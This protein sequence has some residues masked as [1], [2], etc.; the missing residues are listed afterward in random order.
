V[1]DV[2]SRADLTTLDGRRF[3][4]VLGHFPTG[5]AVVAARRADGYP[6]GMVVGSFTSVSLDP[7][8]VAFLPDRTSTTWPVIKASGSFCVSVLGDRQ[9]AVCRAFAAKGGDKFA[10]IGWTPA[11]SG[12][13]IIDGAVAY[14]D[15][16]IET[17]HE[18]GD[19]FIVIGRVRE[20]DQG[21]PAMPLVFLHSAY[22]RITPLSFTA[23]GTD[24]LGQMRLADIARPEIEA[25]AAEWGV[26]CFASAM[27]GDEIVVVA[28]VG[29]PDNALPTRVGQRLPCVP[30]L[31]GIFMAWKDRDAV[32]GWLRRV[33]PGLTDE[34]AASMHD[35]L[36]TIRRRGFSVGIARRSHRKIESLLGRSLREIEP[37]RR[38]VAVDLL[39]ELREDFDPPDVGA[40]S[41]K[42]ARS[43]AVP[44]FSP[45]DAVILTLNVHP[46][47]SPPAAAG[48]Q[49][50]AARLKESAARVAA[51]AT[52]VP[53]SAG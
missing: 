19:H 45:D 48:L 4:E 21:D 20:L 37:E 28:D 39:A 24:L 30:P 7:P 11:A 12:S 2:T 14:I 16:D 51:Q 27:V 40:D 9:E 23:W 33:G 50:C 18:A 38:A 1:T 52:G 8:M 6:V 26:E 29:V 17:V 43:L 46:L 44:V 35:M 49:A 41:L 32:D 36:A 42:F 5:V 25:L 47:P 10:G 22:G 53:A 34:D 3:R 15:C 13:P 31:G